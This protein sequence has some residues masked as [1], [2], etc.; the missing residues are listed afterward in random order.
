MKNRY[1]CVGKTTANPKMKNT[2]H[3]GDCRKR[4]K[5]HTPGAGESE[6]TPV[7]VEAGRG[8]NLLHQ[9]AWTLVSW[10]S[11]ARAWHLRTHFH[12]AGNGERVEDNL[13]EDGAAE[14]AWLAKPLLQRFEGERHASGQRLLGGLP[15]GRT[16]C[17]TKMK[18]ATSRGMP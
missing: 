15:Q 3:K 8:S 13:P 12:K 17:Q 14:Q 2:L 4:A 18:E 5:G 16:A 6:C 1:I 11:W 9:S 7:D 10:H